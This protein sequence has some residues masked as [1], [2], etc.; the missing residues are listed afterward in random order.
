MRLS[1]YDLIRIIMDI[2]GLDVDSADDVLREYLYEIFCFLNGM[3]SIYSSL[4]DLL[5][6]KF[7]NRVTFS[8][9]NDGAIYFMEV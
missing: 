6:D 2:T 5:N 7:H 3:P 4:Q 1:D 9:Q 8:V